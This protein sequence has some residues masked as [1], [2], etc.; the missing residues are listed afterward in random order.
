MQCFE[1]SQA[2][3]CEQCA[4]IGTQGIRRFKITVD[5]SDRV[6]IMPDLS[7]PDYLGITREIVESHR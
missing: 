5:E 2:H 3:I 1:P 6:I 7:A 4:V